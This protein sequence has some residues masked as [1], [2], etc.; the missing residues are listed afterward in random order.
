[1][2]EL[3]PARR[4]FPGWQCWTPAAPQLL[5]RMSLAQSAAQA[6]GLLL[7]P[8]ASLLEAPGLVYKTNRV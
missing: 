6:A 2:C 1:M 8:M 7:D 3:L 5:V 4:V